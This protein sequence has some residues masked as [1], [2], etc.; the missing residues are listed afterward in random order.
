MFKSQHLIQPFHNFETN[1]P[2]I[3]NSFG[4]HLLYLGL[5]TTVKDTLAMGSGFKYEIN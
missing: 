4:H 1:V 2:V 3:F 5:A